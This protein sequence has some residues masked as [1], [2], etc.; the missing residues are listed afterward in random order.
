[1]YTVVAGVMVQQLEA[2][3]VFPE[4]LGSIAST[5]NGL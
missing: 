5:H 2:L 1:V 4:H 3:A